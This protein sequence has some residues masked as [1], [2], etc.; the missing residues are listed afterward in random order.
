[1]KEDEVRR[2]HVLCGRRKEVHAGFWWGNL[3]ER[4]HLEDLGI[5]NIILVRQMLTLI[6]KKRDWL[7]AWSGLICLRIG[8]SGGL[9]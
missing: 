9:S 2:A 4:N 1:M 6:L 7:V 5:D 8:T 3:E